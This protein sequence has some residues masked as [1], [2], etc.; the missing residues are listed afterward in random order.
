MTAAIS[1]LNLVPQEKQSAILVG[2][3]VLL[4]KMLAIHRLDQLYTEHK[5]TGMAT[6]HSASRSVSYREQPS[7]WRH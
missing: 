6:K 1:L 5:L 2:V 7:F 4:D 3:L